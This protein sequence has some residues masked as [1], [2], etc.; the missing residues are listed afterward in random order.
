LKTLF[1]L[2]GLQNFDFESDSEEETKVWPRTF[3]LEGSILANKPVGTDT[4]AIYNH[5]IWLNAQLPKIMICTDPG[6]R[7]KVCTFQKRGFF[8]RGKTGSVFSVPYL[9]VSATRMTI[10]QERQT[11][12]FVSHTSCVQYNEE[13]DIKEYVKQQVLNAHQAHQSPLKM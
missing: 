13:N 4:P 7:G 2:F 11:L 9:L 10:L 12:K 8:P 6:N 3:S 1:C 5:T